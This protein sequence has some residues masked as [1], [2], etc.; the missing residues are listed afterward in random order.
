[1]IFGAITYGRYYFKQLQATYFDLFLLLSFFS[2]WILHKIAKMK[3]TIFMLGT[4]TGVCPSSAFVPPQTYTNNAISLQAVDTAMTADPYVIAGVGAAV[5]AVGGAVIAFGRKGGEKNAASSKRSVIAEP[6][7]L[8]LGI[9]YDAAAELAYNAYLESSSAE[10]DFHQ[11]KGLY[12]E[13]MVAEVKATVQERKVD[14]MMTVLAN[15]QNDASLIKGQVDALFS[16]SSP[17]SGPVPNVV[18]NGRG[19]SGFTS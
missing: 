10:V 17:E 14:E 4:V 8:D 16:E 3:L 13:Q 19:S 1:M 11:F 6:E 15:L 2:S 12:Y 5:S 18:H 7:I 9:P